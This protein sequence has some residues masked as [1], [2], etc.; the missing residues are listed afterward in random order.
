MQRLSRSR[1]YIAHQNMHCTSSNPPASKLCKTQAP[2]THI[3]IHTYTGSVV[4]P[5]GIS[6][7]GFKAESYDGC[8][9]NNKT[10][11]LTLSVNHANDTFCVCLLLCGCHT[12]FSEQLDNNKG[13]KESCEGF[14]SNL[15][16]LMI[17]INHQQYIFESCKIKL[18]HR[19]HSLSVLLCHVEHN[20]A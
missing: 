3:H 6:P 14:D 4:V 5:S 13:S 20:M 7:N 17:P 19:K 16:N 1:H 18:T 10:I 12:I 8:L 2:Y 15:N 9:Y 11:T